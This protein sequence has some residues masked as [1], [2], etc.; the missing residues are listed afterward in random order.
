MHV[1]QY[2]MYTFRYSYSQS[3]EPTIV[4]KS[5]NN[6]KL[7]QATALSRIDKMKINK[8]YDCGEFPMIWPEK[9]R[10]SILRYSYRFC[11]PADD[12]D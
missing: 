1:S 6:I 11:F 4:P 9:L 7:G 8:L 10:C 5:G 3:G 2:C 12:M